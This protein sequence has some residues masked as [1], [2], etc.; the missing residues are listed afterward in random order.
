M[1]LCSL[2][3]L[4]CVPLLLRL[5]TFPQFFYTCF[6]FLICSPLTTSPAWT[7]TESVIRVTSK[8]LMLSDRCFLFRY[9]HL[10]ATISDSKYVSYPCLKSTRKTS[11]RLHH[12]FQ[13]QIRPKNCCLLLPI[14]IN[15]RKKHDYFLGQI[16][17]CDT[18][19]AKGRPKAKA[20]PPKVEASRGYGGILSQDILKIRSSEMRFLAF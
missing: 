4:A 3:K 7:F 5:V 1:F 9:L 12:Q 20:R 17:F 15:R 13:F 14:T 10:A 11:C 16:Q 2:Q 19:W 8:S 18:G 6:A